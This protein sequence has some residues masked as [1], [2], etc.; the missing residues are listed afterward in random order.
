MYWMTVDHVVDDVAIATGVAFLIIRQFA[1][2]TADPGRMA[3]LP[4]VILAIGVG[5]S[6][7]DFMTGYRWHAADWVMAAELVMVTV[8][9]LAMGHVTRFR[10][11]DGR[12]QYK[13]TGNGVWLWGL[14]VVIRI[15]SMVAAVEL[16]AGLATATGPLLVSFAVN[17]IAAIVVVRR[18]TRRIPDTDAVITGPA[19]NRP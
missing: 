15:G 10:S 9:G 8:T 18:R 3:R 14:F 17:R 5:Y 16:G 7:V 6:T 2:R 11:V 13:L 1:W 4:A 12:V 19:P